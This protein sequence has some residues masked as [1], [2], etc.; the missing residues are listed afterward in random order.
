MVSDFATHFVK[1]EA[2]NAQLREELT[3]AKSSTE[4]VEAANRLVEEAWQKNE[5]LE[6]ELAKVKAELEKEVKLKE[7]AKAQAE[8]RED[9]LRRS[10]E[11]LLGVFLCLL[12]CFVH[13]LRRLLQFATFCVLIRRCRHSVGPLEQASS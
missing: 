12:H 1:M 4:Q 3:A 5:D 13:L 8:K 2:E 6:K 10:I 7:K 11:S 9:Q